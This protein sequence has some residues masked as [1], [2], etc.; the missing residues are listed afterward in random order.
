LLKKN[1]IKNGG[2][3]HQNLQVSAPKALSKSDLSVF[4]C[5]RQIPLNLHLKLND[6]WVEAAAPQLK[7][8]NQ[9]KV[10]WQR[11]KGFSQCQKCCS[12][13]N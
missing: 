4:Q 5:I 7:L 8:D 13:I 11:I 10:F 3:V 6:Y 9:L 12:F 1:L 2:P